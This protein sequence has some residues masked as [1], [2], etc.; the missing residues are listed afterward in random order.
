MTT[1][2]ETILFTSLFDKLRHHLGVSGIFHHMIKWINH[3]IP[4][5]IFPRAAKQEISINQ[6]LMDIE[7]AS[8]QRTGLST[9]RLSY[10]G[11]KTYFSYEANNFLEKYEGAKIKVL[12]YFDFK[13]C[14]FSTKAF[15]VVFDVDGEK[16]AVE[17][18]CTQDAKQF[19][20]SSHSTSKVDDY[21]FVAMK[22]DRDIIVKENGKFFIGAMVAMESFGM[23]NWVGIDRKD[24]NRTHVSLKELVN[25]KTFII[26]GINNEGTFILEEITYE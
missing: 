7:D 24:N 26:G 18:K 1:E 21:I 4:I 17:I 2:T 13:D 15:D 11:V 12:E 22:I 16:I 25:D 20:S 5:T 9:V 14:D 6:W 8:N 3:E 23:E 19:Q 10:D